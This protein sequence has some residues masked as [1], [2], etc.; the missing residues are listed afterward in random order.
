MFAKTKRT[1]YIDIRDV[2]VF[3]NEFYDGVR[4]FDV[5]DKSDTAA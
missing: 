2:K 1:Q 3:E 4:M 5:K